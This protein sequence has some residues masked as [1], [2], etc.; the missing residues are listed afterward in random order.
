MKR[1]NFSHGRNSYEEAVTLSLAEN[2]LRTHAL[3][4]RLSVPSHN[5]S[6]VKVWGF[7]LVAGPARSEE[8]ETHSVVSQLA[9][10]T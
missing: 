9:K 2:T 7:V 6:L 4:H 10:P 1:R 3:L 5:A 8:R